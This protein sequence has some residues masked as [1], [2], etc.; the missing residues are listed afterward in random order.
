MIIVLHFIDTVN[1][2]FNIYLAKDILYSYGS[3]VVFIKAVLIL[4]SRLILY[5]SIF[6]EENEFLLFKSIL[7]NKDKNTVRVKY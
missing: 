2:N 7:D 4:Q 6:S 1:M 3:N 5:S